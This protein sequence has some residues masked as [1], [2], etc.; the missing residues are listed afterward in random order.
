MLPY[1]F[2]L[3]ISAVFPLIVYRPAGVFSE[4]GF[5]EF[6]KKRSK[7]TF[8]LFF[9]GFF[10]L[11]ALRDI[12]VGKDL[13]EYEVIFNRCIAT[14]FENLSKMRWEL[15]YTFY[16]K[17]VSIVSTNYRVFLI[18][19]ALFVLVPIYKLYSQEKKYSFIAIVL[20]INMPCFLMIFSGLRQAIAISIGILVYMA[21]E[22]KKYILSA[23]LLLL[24]M[25]FHVSAFILILLYPAT[26]FK[27]KAKHLLYIVPIMLGIYLLRIPI[28]SL[29]IGFL[30]SKYI[31][32]YGKLQQ[33]GAFGMMI[34]FLAFFVFAFV[35]LDETLM[36]KKDYFLRNVLL[37]A[38]IF[39]FFVPIHGLIQRASYYFLIFVPI[40]IVSV[41]QAPKRYL[42]NI[43]NL[44]AV[45]IGVFFI[46]YFFYN[47]AFSTDNLLGVFP[48]KFFWSGERW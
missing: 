14:S 11:L 15:G 1:F 25:S 19:T 31:E 6:I 45:V 18:L 47:A 10:I 7:L 46:L 5:N 43:S 9:L 12:T 39:Q 44:G 24:A 21:I 3:F 22:N 27:I 2:L 35:I 13:P 26:V 48:Y 40:S 33:T 8:Q 41:L 29:L 23:L 36:S 32:F 20:F 42:K 4:T 38:T 28:F 30:P 34:L 16:N 17:L 37:I